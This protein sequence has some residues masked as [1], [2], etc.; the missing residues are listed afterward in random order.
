MGIRRRS[1]IL[2]GALAV[3]AAAVGA[4]SAPAG[5]APAGSFTQHTFT[6]TGGVSR[7]YWLYEPSGPATEP[8]P[9]VVYLHGCNQT[10]VDAA[11]G[12]RWNALA[13]QRGFVVAYPEQRVNPEEGGIGNGNG[14]GCWNWFLPEHQQR[15]V[16]EPALIAGITRAVTATRGVDPSRV[17]VIGASAGAN[18]AVIMS[19]TYPD[20]YAAV[21]AFAGCAYA[22]CSDVTGEAAFAA[23]DTRARVVPAMIVQGT[24]D[25]LNNFAMGETMVRQ[26]VG[27]ADLADG[28][29][30]GSPA[31][32][33]TDTEHVGF[34]ASL[35]DNAGT[36]GDLCVRNRQ[37][38][39][40]GAVL[41]LDDYPYSVERH[42]N[43]A[44]CSVVDFWIIHGLGHDYPGGDPAFTFTDP[45]GPDS[46][47]AAYDFFGKHQLGA[48]PCA[49]AAAEPVV[50]E[51][52]AFLL[53]IAAVGLLAVAARRRARVG[54]TAAAA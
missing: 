29:P 52:P 15:D 12:T 9:L 2:L 42:A 54:T 25:V 19:A 23:M 14:I 30:D 48:A 36:I 3:V 51:A 8:R 43:T 53:P 35:A 37:F 21:A 49:G 4:S 18:M 27:T 41:G 44:G 50:P 28:Q 39:C 20:L 7:G 26:Q 33:P 1:A 32:V 38:P 13:E 10:A 11:G 45:I 47:T 16:G 22:T 31:Q 34:D 17:Y 5:A 6:G 46:T 40:A 24:V